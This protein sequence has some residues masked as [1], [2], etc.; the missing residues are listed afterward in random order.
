MNITDQRNVFNIFHDG[1]ISEVSGQ[2]DLLTLKIEIEYLAELISLD[3]KY[4]YVDLILCDEIK[5]IE[6]DN[7]ETFYDTSKISELEPEILDCDNDV[8]DKLK[9][10]CALSVGSGGELWITTKDIKLFDQK[11]TELSL[12]ELENICDKYWDGF[13]KK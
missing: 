6:W 8:S 2:Y 12:E 10:F 1:Y 7:N 4:F 9:I 11:R 3:Y 5:F 13:G